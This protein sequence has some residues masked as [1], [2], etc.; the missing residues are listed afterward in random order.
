MARDGGWIVTSQSITEDLNYF[1]LKRVGW[2]FLDLWSIGS[3]PQFSTA[4]AASLSPQF[5]EVRRSHRRRICRMVGTTRW[6]QTFLTAATPAPHP[7]GS[8]L[9]GCHRQMAALIP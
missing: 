5:H 2:L 3:R 4:K 9:R 1:I 7:S 6:A 8:R